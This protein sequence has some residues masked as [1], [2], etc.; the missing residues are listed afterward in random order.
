LCRLHGLTMIYANVARKRRRNHGLTFE[1]Q[2]LMSPRVLRL[3]GLAVLAVLA[4]TC[5]AD[6]AGAQTTLRYKFKKGEKLNYA[7]E[8]K[9]VMS[10]SV[11]GRDV[12]LDMGQTID[13]VWNV[14]DVDADGKAKMTQTIS[15]I[16]FTM[17]GPTGKVEFD[18]KEGKEPDDPVGK[19]MAPIFKALAGA[20]IGLTMDPLGKISDIKVPEKLVKAAKNLPPGLAGAGLGD[21][22]SEEGLKQITDQSGLRLPQ[23]AVTKG[24]SWE[25]QLEMKMPMGKMKVVTTNTYE[26]S[27]KRDGKEVERVGMKPKLTLDPDPAS[28]AKITLKSQ[29]AKGSAYFDNAAGRLVGTNLSQD[30]EMVIS[31]MG[32]EIT[33]KLKQTVSMKLV[34]K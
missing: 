3:V 9:M 22:L 10:M 20:E 28:P 21:M 19:L 33:Q 15:R 4:I 8:Q 11:M 34:D 25:Q 29:D 7:M 17:D 16:R 27:V 18:S 26:G 30:M 5:T 32:Q 13:M 1:R 12:N 23:D 24:K 31:A 2:F 6:R 14:L